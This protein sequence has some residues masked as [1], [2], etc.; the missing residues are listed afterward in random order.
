MFVSM[1]DLLSTDKAQNLSIIW[2]DFQYFFRLG[3]FF[4]LAFGRSQFWGQFHDSLLL[5]FEFSPI[6]L[7]KGE[8]AISE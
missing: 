6:Y 7:S 4:L 3:F 2:K 1:F 8:T 5:N